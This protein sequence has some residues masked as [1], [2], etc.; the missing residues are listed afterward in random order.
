MKRLF[1][2]LW[3]KYVGLLT[4]C[5]SDGYRVMPYAVQCCGCKNFLGTT[6]PVFHPPGGM[7][8]WGKVAGFNSHHTANTIAAKCGWDIGDG[9]D[10]RCPECLARIKSGGDRGTSQG[11]IVRHG[12]Y[13]GR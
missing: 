13:R 1:Q 7:I 3:T 6:M 12:G 9:T 8:D 4:P 5:Q 2:W 11:A 10:H